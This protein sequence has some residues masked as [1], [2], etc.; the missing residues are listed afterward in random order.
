MALNKEIKS[1]HLFL[2]SYEYNKEWYEE[3]ESWS[4]VAF[5]PV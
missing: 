1:N 3:T 4:D 2:E 5:Q